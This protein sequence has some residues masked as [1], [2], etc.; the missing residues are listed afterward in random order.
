MAEAAQVLGT[1]VAAVK[2]RAHRAYEAL[3]A[4][5]GDAI[6]GIEGGQAV[7]SPTAPPPSCARASWRR[8]RA[9]PVPAA[10]RR[11]RARASS[12]PSSR[13]SALSVAVLVQHRR[14]R[15]GRAAGQRTS[16]RWPRSGSAV[17]AG[18]VVGRAWRAVS[19][20]L[21]RPASVR[22]LVAAPARPRRCSLTALLAGL[23]WPAEMTEPATHVTSTSSASSFTIAHGA[24][25][26]RRLRLRA[27]GSDPVAPRL[28]GAAI[29]AAA[30]AW[31]ALCIELRCEPRLASST[32]LLGHV[33]PVALLALVGWSSGAASSPA[34]VTKP[35][36]R[37]P[38]GRDRRRHRRR[39]GPAGRRPRSRCCRRAP[40]VGPRRAARARALPAG[41]A[42]RRRRW[43]SE[44]TRCCASWA[45]HVDVPERAG[46]RDGPALRRG[47]GAS[48]RPGAHRARRAAHRVRP[49]PRAHRASRAGVELRDGVRVEAVRDERATA[50]AVVETSAGPL[51]ARVVVGC[52]GVGS[53]VRKALG[54]GAGRLRAQVVEVD[55]QPVPG[56][57]ERTLLHFDATDRTLARLRVGLPDRRRTAAS[58][59]AAASTG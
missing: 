40:T 51:R 49:R 56:D 48:R 58:S 47:R 44:A 15:A 28:T 20:M 45:S 31:G 13:A 1:T 6:G 36:V 43:G 2:L 19:S 42:L 23:A 29:G 50:G 52:D 3:R 22:V 39:A 38:E 11:A 54:R 16:S 41:Q 33:M 26:S 53:V 27:A 10:A 35:L 8:R 55:T 9:E 57:R 59:S 17:G 46:R 4:A 32:S 7:M 25:A 18:R 14:A 5:L 12:S 24:R 37:T 21:G 30:G 34:R